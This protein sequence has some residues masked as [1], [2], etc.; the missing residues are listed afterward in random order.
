MG[1]PKLDGMARLAKRI[2]QLEKQVAE[3]SRRTMGQ[4][5]FGPGLYPA[6]EMPDISK[7]DNWPPKFTPESK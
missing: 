4:Q 6:P 7:L 3:L 1:K 2:E 5:M